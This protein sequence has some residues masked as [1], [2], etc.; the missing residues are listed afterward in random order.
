MP[1]EILAIGDLHLGRRPGRL[2]PGFDSADLSPRAAWRAAV[3]EARRRKVDAV[4]LLGDVVDDERAFFEAYSSLREQV[5]NLID[6]GIQVV[7][8]AGNHDVDV[9]P[10]L[11][12]EVP[13]LRV[14]G[15]RGRWEEIVLD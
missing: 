2:P 4:L 13:G 14:L 9:L 3:A 12:R 7:A 11:A 8:I 6:D 15:E 10:R 5:R 1:L